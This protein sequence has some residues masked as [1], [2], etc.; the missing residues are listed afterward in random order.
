M[1]M[2]MIGHNMKPRFIHLFFMI[3]LISPQSLF[4][5]DKGMSNTRLQELITRIVKNPAGRTGSWS[6]KY[7]DIPIFIIT[8]EKANRMR[9]ISPISSS[10]NLSKEALYRMMQA[11]FDSALDAR[12]SIAQGKLWSSSNNN[13]G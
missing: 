3:I 9:I 5:A 12:Y 8:S 1:T 2:E 7:E 10:D 6:I 4:A 11:N 13:A